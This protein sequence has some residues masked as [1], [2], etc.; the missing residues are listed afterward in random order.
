M[1][2]YEKLANIAKL[3]TI[4][5][6]AAVDKHRKLR[7]APCT[8]FEGVR[9]HLADEIKKANTELSK[10]KASTID[11]LHLPSF[12]EEVFLTYGTDTLCRVGRGIMKGGCR[13]TAVISGPPNGYEISRREYLCKQ[14][15]TCRIVLTIDEAKDRTLA[16]SPDGVAA[17]IVAG[18]LVGKFN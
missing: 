7:A 13:I 6:R 17:D 10:K 8:F 1:T 14:E 3:K 2:D 12:D 4:E 15:E 16:F 9:A 18:I 5:D 11:R